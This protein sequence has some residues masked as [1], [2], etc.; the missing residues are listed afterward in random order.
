[1]LTV[2]LTGS[3]G[4]GKSTVAAIWQEAGIPVLSADEV[5][6]E[7]VRVGTPGLDAVV[8]AFG[9][10]ILDGTG[11]LDRDAVRKIVFDDREARERLESIVHPLIRLRRD[12]WVEARRGEGARLVV[13]EVP[14]LFEVGLSGDFDVSV[15]IAADRE[16]CL[17]RLSAARGLSREE[18]MKI[19]SVQMEP[20]EKEAMADYVV[21]NNGT[22]GE[23]RDRALSLLDLLRARSRATADG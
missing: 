2:A 7:V 14:L 5:A 11:A 22:L 4:A 13:A 18:G 3:V 15:M 1:M 23:L 12:E 19:W 17:D 21:H 10:R 8:E 9:S 16:V 20:A 6:R